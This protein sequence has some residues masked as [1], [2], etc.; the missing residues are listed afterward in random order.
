MDQGMLPTS[1]E[2]TIRQA[3]GIM[4]T[5]F[6]GSFFRYQRW[7][8]DDKFIWWRML[9]DVPGSIVF[10]V[11]ALA[12]SELLFKNGVSPWVPGGIAGFMGM[13]GPGVIEALAARFLG[14][15]EK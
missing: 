10:G 3:L 12:L 11:M 4:A 13:S 1:T 6:L 2:P 15:K 8:I 7:I 14:G 5:A 9:L